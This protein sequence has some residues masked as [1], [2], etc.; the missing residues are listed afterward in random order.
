[1][2]VSRE[3]AAVFLVPPQ[4][5]SQI[6]GTDPEFLVELLGLV[7]LGEAVLLVLLDL[8][9]SNE[10]AVLRVDTDL[11]VGHAPSIEQR[12]LPRGRYRFFAQHGGRVRR[13]MSGLRASG[14]RAD[15]ASRRARALEARR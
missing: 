8:F 4:K 10:V 3:E 11:G 6:A 2:Q 14:G 1:A 7:C 5:S 9:E 13:R 15:G 12:R